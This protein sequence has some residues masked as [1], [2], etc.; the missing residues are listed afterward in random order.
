[1]H[2]YIANVIVNM[3]CDFKKTL[4]TMICVA[5]VNIE[6]HTIF[7]CFCPQ[8]NRFIGFMACF[9]VWELSIMFIVLT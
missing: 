1:M 4:P 8:C 3:S 2:P 5:I 9:V 7:I 6:L